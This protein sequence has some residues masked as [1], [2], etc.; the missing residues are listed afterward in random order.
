MQKKLAAIL[1]IAIFAVSTLAIVNPVHATF[2]LGQYQ[3]LPPY[4]T[5]DYDPHVPGFMGYVWPGGGSAAYSGA[6]S[7]KGPQASIN[8]AGGYSPGYVPPYPTMPPSKGAMLC[9]GAPCPESWYQLSGNSYAPFGA[10]LAGSTGDLI[11]AI[12]ATCQYTGTEN[13]PTNCAFSGWTKGWQGLSILLPPE[14]KVPGS[15]Q[16]VTSWTND[17]DNYAVATLAPDDRYA[18]GWTMVSVYV[19][20]EQGQS[21]IAS[22]PAHCVSGND[23]MC[24]SHSVQFLNF[25]SAGEWYYVRI[26]GVTAPSVAGKYFFK[27]LLIGDNGGAPLGANQGLNMTQFVPVQNWPVLLVKGELD[28]A[29]ITGT[30]VYGGYNSTMYNMPL[31]M[32]GRVWAE[33]TTKLDPY[34]GATVATC[35]AEDSPGVPSGG[36]AAVPGCTDSVGYFNETAHGHYELEGLAPGVYSIYAEAAGYPQMLEES[37]VTVLRGQSLHFPLSLQPGPVIHGNVFTK[38]QFGDEPWPSSPSES[39]AQYMKIEFYAKPTLSN[40]V[41]PSAGPPVAWSPLPCVAGGQKNTIVTWSSGHTSASWDDSPTGGYDIGLGRDASGCGAPASGSNIGFPWTRYMP[42]GSLSDDPLN[43]GFG[44]WS[45]IQL[46]QP[47]AGVNTQDPMGVGPP[48]KWVVASGTTTPFHF[49]F[50]VKGEYGAPRDL[51]GHVPE[52]YAT[53]VNGLTAGRYYVRAWNFRYVQTAL[54][55]ATFQEYYFD[56][57]PNEWAGDVTLPLDLRLSSWVNKTVY[58]HDGYGEIATDPIRTSA[59]DLYGYLLGA[60][61]HIYAFNI[62]ALSTTPGRWCQATSGECT[63]QFWGI[64]NTWVGENYGIPSGTYTAITKAMGYAELTAPEQVSVTLSGNPTSVSDHMYLAGGFNVTVYSTDWERPT[65]PRNWL[66]PG[67]SLQVGAWLNGTLADVADNDVGNNVVGP[68]YQDNTKAYLPLIGTG[69]SLWAGGWFGQE[70]KPYIGGIIGQKAAFLE[71][72][73]PSD[74]S[75]TGN[76][77]TYF[78]PGLYQFSGTTY[79]YI[80]DQVFSAY[81][82][83]GQLADVRINLV[84]GVNVSL[85]ILFKKESIITPTNMNMSTRVRLFDDSGKLV[86]DFL[87]SAGVYSENNTAG[88]VSGRAAAADGEL[89]VTPTGG[90]FPDTKDFS[91]IGKSG[92]DALPATGKYTNYLPGGVTLFHVTIAGREMVRNNFEGDS[93]MCDPVFGCGD[94]GEVGGLMPSGTYNAGIPGASDYTGGWTAEVDFVPW[95]ANN[96]GSP[97]TTPSY[98]PPVNGL[99]MGESFHIIPGTTAT[100]GISLTEDGALSILKSSMAPNHL[101]PYSQE[102]VWQIAGTHNSGEASA[103]FEVDLNGFVSGNTFAMDYA[104]EWRTTSWYTIT[105][106]GASG[107]P[108]WNFYTFDGMYQAYLPTGSYSFTIAGPGVT[109]QTM[110]LVVSPGQTSTGTNFYL[111]E[112]QVPVPEFS[113]IAIVAFAALG[114]SVYLLRRRRK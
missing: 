44:G 74:A 82:T 54:D 55:G 57:T 23:A 77:P 91:A 89:Y 28:P 5:L 22:P 40:K 73:T 17:Y 108:S 70:G 45:Q 25:T 72:D 61:G 37:G 46:A 41:D 83:W 90:P 2:T 33:M 86:G 67:M 113:S 87:S 14:F 4:T 18:P 64:D 94:V 21:Y 1:T 107:K 26:N 30:V 65:V 53:W 38:H 58:F 63:I 60:D 8:S 93:G 101:G 32:A 112:S 95:Y 84:I 98:Y 11:F 16:V 9:N 51:D 42:V 12:N 66:Y 3:G 7:L 97:S 27:M 6:Y 114:A 69:T 47:I 36:A 109:S 49:E 29:I 48:Q 15:Q 19:D 10:V 111:Q 96:T 59:Q 81:T 62:T 103:I 100:S 76:L 104:N 99:L 92:F 31:D 88:L 56:V 13:S 75:F 110:A 35:P 106:A 50:G 34:T 43:N 52:V 24:E 71:S 105:V 39:E 79:G 78:L 80:Q 102:G 85:S 68:I 20:G